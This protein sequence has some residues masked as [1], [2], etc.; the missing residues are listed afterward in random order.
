FRSRPEGRGHF[1]L[2]A[3]VARVKLLFEGERVE[4]RGAIGAG[5]QV[6]AHRFGRLARD[7]SVEILFDQ[8]EAIHT[9]HHCTPPRYG[10]MRL[11]ISD[12]ARCKS[13]LS[14]PTEKPVISA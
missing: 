11:R 2:V 13:V 14:L 9:S 7:L 8:R 3:V 5:R 10:P 1:E 4:R 12:R 6:R